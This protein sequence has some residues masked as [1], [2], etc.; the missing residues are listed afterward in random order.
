[1]VFVWLSPFNACP[2]FARVRARAV[3]DCVFC[4]LFSLIYPL[5][6]GGK[7]WKKGRKQRKQ[8]KRG[9]TLCLL[10]ERN[11][12]FFFPLFD[13]R[14]P[15]ARKKLCR[16]NRL[17]DVSLIFSFIIVNSGWCFRRCHPRL[18]QL[19]PILGHW[20]HQQVQ[21]WSPRFTHGLCADGVRLVQRSDEPQPE[22]LHV[23]Q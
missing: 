2:V 13:E 17:T 18:D 7:T 6:W 21:F 14:P 12:S 3:S 19:H 4:S 1:M 5:S 10:R 20:C 22:R 11:L 23:A 15:V 8:G 16:N 9:R